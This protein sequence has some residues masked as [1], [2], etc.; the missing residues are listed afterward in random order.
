MVG[1]TYKITW[2]GTDYICTAVEIQGAVCIG[3]ATV[4][5]GSGNDEPF[6]MMAA[7][8]STTIVALVDGVEHTISLSLL[9]EITHPMAPEFLSTETWTFT[10]EDGSTVTKK[11]AIGE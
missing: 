5:G 11:V 8:Y 7:G 10:F 9:S 1:D 6:L 2:D 3:N 4:M